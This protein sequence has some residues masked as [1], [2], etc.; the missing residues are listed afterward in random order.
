MHVKSSQLIA[1]TDVLLS[2]LLLSYNCLLQH[3]LHIESAKD[4]DGARLVAFAYS[5]HSYLGQ[6]PELSRMGEASCL[7]SAVIIII[8]QWDLKYNAYNMN[9]CTL[10]QQASV[11]TPF[12][13]R[14]S[15]VFVAAIKSSRR[16]TAYAYMRCQASARKSFVRSTTSSTMTLG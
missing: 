1:S 6:C 16:F 4:L 15:H 9:V 8:I 10:Y 5:S 7:Y 11:P 3:L 14:D 13:H 12:A 2:S